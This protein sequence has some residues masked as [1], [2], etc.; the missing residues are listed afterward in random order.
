MV[1]L[2]IKAAFDS[3]WHGGLVIKIINLN[4]PIELTKIIPSFPTYSFSQ[5]WEA[6]SKFLFASGQDP[7]IV[8]INEL[9]SS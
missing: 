4:F 9:V 5:D 2:D 1:L 8:H 3:V 6:Y 7:D